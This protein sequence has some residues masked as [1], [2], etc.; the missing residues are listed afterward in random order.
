MHMQRFHEFHLTINK[1]KDMSEKITSKELSTYSKEN[2]A[3]QI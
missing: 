1:C 3:S 2:E